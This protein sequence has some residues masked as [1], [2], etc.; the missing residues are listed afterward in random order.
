MGSPHT[1][2]VTG[3]AADLCGSLSKRLLAPHGLTGSTAFRSTQTLESLVNALVEEEG[4][5]ERLLE[6]LGNL[7]RVL[8]LRVGQSID[9]ADDE[10]IYHLGRV[11]AMVRELEARC[12][13]LEP[14]GPGAGAR[15][16]VAGLRDR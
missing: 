9:G 5:D 12:R 6:A 16:E 8:T 4:V 2:A 11:F 13:R 14:R 7:V 10:E 15:S 3:V 1:F